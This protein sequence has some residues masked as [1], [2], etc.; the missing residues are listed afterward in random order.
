MLI[1]FD[2]PPKV[3]KKLLDLTDMMLIPGG[4]ADLISLSGGTTPYQDTIHEMIKYALN[5][6]DRG[7]HYPVLATCLG[8][9]NLIISVANQNTSV[10][11]S[12]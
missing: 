10:L 3:I 9:E 2:L 8:F 11:Q 4:P 1:P 12:R 6:N 7:K 5:R